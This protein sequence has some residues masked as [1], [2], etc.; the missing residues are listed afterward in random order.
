M[1][2]LYS[3][4]I[5]KKNQNYLEF[6]IY[7]IGISATSDEDVSAFRAK[8]VGS[9][10]THDK[11]RSSSFLP[12]NV[13]EAVSEPADTMPV[14]KESSTAILLD[15]W[16]NDSL[17]L[18]LEFDAESTQSLRIQPISNLEPVSALTRGAVFIEEKAI[19]AQNL[20]KEIEYK[21]ENSLASQLQPTNMSRKSSES[22]AEL[23]KYISCSENVSEPVEYSVYGDYITPST[24]NTE[25]NDAVIIWNRLQAFVQST[26]LHMPTA[27]EEELK[28]KETESTDSI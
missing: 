13:D 22:V 1:I 11:S 6:C 26:E 17:L 21:P 23:P 24:Q 28:H 7:Q 10:A 19:E 9:L 14:E 2:W 20:A 27:I 15:A 5:F 16:I 4:L 18:N 8:H 12:S 3:F 25:T